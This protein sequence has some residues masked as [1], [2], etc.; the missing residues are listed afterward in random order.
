[1]DIGSIV[2]GFIVKVVTFREIESFDICSLWVN[3]KN[4][5]FHQCD[6]MQEIDKKFYNYCDSLSCLHAIEH[7]GLGRYGDQIQY[8]GYLK[9]FENI[10]KI[11]KTNGKFYLSIPIGPQRIVFNA[12]RVFS[13]S[14]LLK[15][16][17]SMFKIN[18][19]SY[20]DDKDTFHQDVPIEKNGVLTNYGC[21]YGCGIFEMTKL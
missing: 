9:G 4:I 19:F 7:F 3:I 10:A 6:L 16:F 12:H 2:D 14:Y 18:G 17:K 20:I 13:I 5:N 15:L 8:E 1:M 11:L 21:L